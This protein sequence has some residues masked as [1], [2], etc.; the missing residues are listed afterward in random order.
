MVSQ[1]TE[2]S[3]LNPT[4]CTH[5]HCWMPGSSSPPGA[6]TSVGVGWSSVRLLRSSGYCYPRSWDSIRYRQWF[7]DSKLSSTKLPSTMWHESVCGY[8]KSYNLVK[9]HYCIWMIVSANSALGILE[10]SQ[11]SFLKLSVSVEA[12]IPYLQL[13]LNTYWK[14]PSRTNSVPPLRA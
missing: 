9:N 11:M 5:N 2:W 3:P 1:S 4:T 6:S 12:F 7:D 8:S 10:P 14:Y 13:S